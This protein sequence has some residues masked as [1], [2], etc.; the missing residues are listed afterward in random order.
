MFKKNNPNKGKRSN[1]KEGVS[2]GNLQNQISLKNG[3]KNSC[4]F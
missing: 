4:C 3:H 1:N 2:K